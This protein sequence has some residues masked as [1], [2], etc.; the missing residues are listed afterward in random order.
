MKFFNKMLVAIFCLTL[1]TACPAKRKND[2]LKIFKN[3][4]YNFSQFKK[5]SY[6]G[7]TA[8]IPSYFVKAY[9]TGFLL[10]KDALSLYDPS[11]HIYISIECFS[12]KEAE[13]IHSS[14]V[15]GTTLLDAVNTS[16]MDTRYN[17]LNNPKVSIVL[18]N[19]KKAKLKGYHEF[20]ENKANDY[21]YGNMIYMMTTVEKKIDHE[22][23]YYV[24]QLISPPEFSKYLKDDFIRLVNGLY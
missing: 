6:K 21:E 18:E 9:N 4:N 8:Y 22:M 2:T 11:I 7:I 17:S 16:Y 24:I 20:I 1:L 23:Y 12:N 5:Y 10:K 19:P 14:F 13:E 15:E 3:N